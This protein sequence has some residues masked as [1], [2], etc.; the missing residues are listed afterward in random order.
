MEMQE[1]HYKV[2]M[3]IPKI[4]SKIEVNVFT[5]GKV[6]KETIKSLGIE[7][8]IKF[9]EE[10]GYNNIVVSDIVPIGYVDKGAWG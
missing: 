6:S 1:N 10:T 5:N 9:L 2:T 3:E 8:S 7:R 4:Q